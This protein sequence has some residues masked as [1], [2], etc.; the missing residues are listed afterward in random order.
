MKRK[1]LRRFGGAAVGDAALVKLVGCNFHDPG[2]FGGNENGVGTVRVGNGDFD[3]SALKILLATPEADTA[4]GHVLTGDDVIG[5]ARPPDARFV[6]NFR[7]LMLAT[8][9]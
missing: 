7:A 6:G 3:G 9:V 1:K 8:I 4:F 5:E 2:D